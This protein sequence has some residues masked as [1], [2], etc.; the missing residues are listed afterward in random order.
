MGAT[1]GKKLTNKIRSFIFSDKLY[2]GKP[3]E[4]SVLDAVDRN[5]K[6]YAKIPEDQNSN[7]LLSSLSM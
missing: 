7:I 1:V 4:G 3:D 6:K 5:N 2:N